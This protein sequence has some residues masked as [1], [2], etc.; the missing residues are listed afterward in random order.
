MVVVGLRLEGLPMSKASEAVTPCDRD[1][2]TRVGL[3]NILSV[4]TLTPP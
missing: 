2:P 4:C 1:W 3:E